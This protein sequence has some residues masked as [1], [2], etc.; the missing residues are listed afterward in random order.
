MA[1]VIVDYVPL[2]KDTEDDIKKGIN[3][4]LQKINEIFRLLS[5]GINMVEFGDGSTTENMYT[6]YVPVE[7]GVAGT[8]LSGTHA[9]GKI[10]TAIVG[11]KLDRAGTVYFSKAA[12]SS[13]IYLK[14]DTDSLSGVIIVA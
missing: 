13:S 6:D 11:T 3:T 9:L 5:T 2:I 14:S 4:S 10:P 8:E 1:R 7:F 12:T